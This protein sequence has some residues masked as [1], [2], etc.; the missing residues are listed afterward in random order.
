LSDFGAT[1]AFMNDR[2]IP[3]ALVG[4]NSPDSYLDAIRWSLERAASLGGQTLLYVPLRGR[5]DAHTALK[6]FSRRGDV[7]TATWKSL[8]RLRW[9]GGV[10]VAAWPDAD[11]LGRIDS[12]PR[13]RALCVLA[14]TEPDVA[15]WARARSPEVLGGAPVAL[16]SDWA[17]DPVVVV[18]LR[19]L[20]QSVNHG[21]NLAG[22][23]DRD[24]A[25]ATL[26]VLAREGF[27]LPSEEIYA[28]ALSHD[29]PHRGAQRLQ[30]LAREISDGKRKRVSGEWPFVDHIADLWRQEALADR[31]NEGG[32]GSS[33]GGSSGKDTGR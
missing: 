24:E 31:T 32:G 1:L 4:V 9:S 10:V 28:F 17:L 22:S 30:Q 6:D 25:I 3:T 21:N 33:N 5:Q 8:S 11:H 18:A 26:T 19:R 16:S 29:W 2:V 12:D 7:S 20:G 14:W 13:T 23:A 27:A 15:G